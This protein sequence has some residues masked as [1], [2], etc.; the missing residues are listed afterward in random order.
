MRAAGEESVNLLSIFGRCIAAK[1]TIPIKRM[2][3]YNLYTRFTTNDFSEILD[4]STQSEMTVFNSMGSND[5][6]TV[7]TDDSWRVHGVHPT[8]HNLK[9][10][11]TDNADKEGTVV[12]GKF[13]GLDRVY[14]V[15]T[16]RGNSSSA[17]KPNSTAATPTTPSTM[18]P[19]MSSGATSVN[20]TP[21]NM[22]DQRCRSIGSDYLAVIQ[23]N[24][25]TM[26]HLLLSD[27]WILSDDALFRLCQ[28]CRDLEQ[29]GFACAI[30]PLESMR[31][32]LTLVP[33]LWAVR[34]LIR[35]GTDSTDKFDMTDPD[36]H[37]FALATE[38]WRPEYKNIKYVGFGDDLVFKLGDVYFPPDGKESKVNGHENSMNAKRAGPIR[39]VELVSRE[40]VKDIEI[41]G[42][43]TTEFDP[44]FP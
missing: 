4:P 35:P 39:K 30:P 10:I 34:L 38:F 8:A 23:T 33:K 14:I 6:A 22:T 18:T 44:T 17:S 13:T 16:R 40:S 25:R 11:R 1:S 7:F 9:M 29:L 43:D 32:V 36:M 19:G 26:R 27:R 15:S 5:P 24:H 21:N 42:L 37:A 12:M 2:A 20:G 3:I 28:S 31:Q 41:W